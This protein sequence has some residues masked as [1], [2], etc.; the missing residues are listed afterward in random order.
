[1]AIF[2]LQVKILGREG[3][4]AV[5]SAAYQSAQNLT[6]SED[7]K[8]YDYQKKTGV[9]YSEIMLPEEAPELLKDRSELW[10]KV[11]S[12]ETRKNA[13]F[14][15]EFV[16]AL[17]N[18]LELEEHKDIL[19]QFISSNF[20]SQ[21]YVADFAIHEKGNNPHAHI[22]VTTRKIEKDGNWQKYK[23]RKTYALDNDGN[24]IP[25]LD[26]DGKQRIGQRGRRMWKS[27]TVQAN[28]LNAL[29]KVEEWRSSWADTCNAH[30]SEQDHIDHRSY[31]R[32][33]LALEATKHEGLK[34]RKQN[35]KHHNNKII[36]SNE[37]IKVRNET[38]LQLVNSLI[39]NLDRIDTL[40]DW[41]SFEDLKDQKIQT[42]EEF[43]N[44]NNTRTES[45]ATTA[46]RET[47][48]ATV[49]NRVI[50][51]ERQGNQKSSVSSVQPSSLDS[52]RK[53]NN[54]HVYSSKTDTVQ[55]V[56]RNSS[57]QLQSV[58]IARATATATKQDIDRLF[59]QSSDFML[60]NKTVGI[61]LPSGTLVADECSQYKLV[62]VDQWHTDDFKEKLKT[63]G[64]ENH[65]WV[66]LSHGNKPGLMMFKIKKL[67][68]LAKDI[69]S[70][71]KK[72]FAD[73]QV[74]AE[75]EAQRLKER[76]TQRLQQEREHNQNTRVDLS[77]NVQ[78]DLKENKT[79]KKY[80]GR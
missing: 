77:V 44:E 3:K 74:Q 78:E 32:Q 1:M 66:D 30:L 37:D 50:R 2:H 40:S 45:A 35:A 19:H 12:L 28:D 48:T 36:Q 46:Q 60:L 42:F 14:A 27:I 22:L 11:Q 17:P 41:I 61:D 72:K 65:D 51:K 4:S 13:Q 23:E 63:K 18:E 16:V 8:T 69:F 6:N 25:V 49:D 56:K 52:E 54:L 39:S 10:N 80:K 79:N 53:R 34:A 62:M 24:K 9:I 58:S 5:A 71:F 57:Q 29:D 73:K 31:A 26:K 64:K 55:S 21:G 38:K 15:K 68:D 76:E 75:A 59:K 43:V 7:G 33:G 67:I 70:D 47:V 20:T